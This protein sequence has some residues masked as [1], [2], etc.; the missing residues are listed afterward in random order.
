MY[1][2]IVEEVKNELQS[3]RGIEKALFLDENDRQKISELENKDEQTASRFL[4]IKKN[5]GIKEA[6]RSDVLISFLTN[7][8]FDWPKNT[9]KLV[10]GEQIVGEDISDPVELRR[11]KERSDCFV[12]GNIVVYCNDFIKTKSSSEPLLMVINSKP[13]PRIE[14]IPHVSGAILASPSRFTDEY[15][16]S[17]MDIKNE[18]SYGTF[19]I[20]FDISKNIPKNHIQ[21]EMQTPCPL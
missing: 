2:Q 15:I 11:Y 4:G 7:K 3:I 13:F 12:V 10:Q 21:N 17:R 9:L 1:W 19:L 6:F 20:G 16:K 5:V 8:E 14:K 18:G